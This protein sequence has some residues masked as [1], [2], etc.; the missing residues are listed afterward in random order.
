M[1]IS[2]RTNKHASSLGIVLGIWYQD[3]Q[4]TFL[5]CNSGDTLHQ[6][7]S[8]VLLLSSSLQFVPINGCLLKTYMWSITHYPYQQEIHHTMAKNTNTNA[9]LK[10]EQWWL[11]DWAPATC[12]GDLVEFS[13]HGFSI[14]IVPAT[15]NKRGRNMWVEA[16]SVS[17]KQKKKMAKKKKAHGK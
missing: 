15:A 12:A 2:R 7:V 13:T 14:H 11:S 10:G 9:D 8:V 1:P 17:P 6:P 3:K 16:L 4:A 5:I